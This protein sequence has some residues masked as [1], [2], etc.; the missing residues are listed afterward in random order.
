M[1]KRRLSTQILASQLTILV[2]TVLIGFGLFASAERD[3][4]DQE[5]KDRALAMADT[6][7]NIP[8]IREAME[9]GDPG[10]LVQSTVER[11]RVK[12]RAAYIVVIDLQGVRHSH[13]NP[14]LIGRRVEEPLIALDGRDH[15]GIDH[16]SLGLSA[17]GKAPIYG[18]SGNLV[19]EVSAGILESEVTSALHRELPVFA[20]YFG[21][22]LAVGVAASYLLARRLKRT[23]FGL[24][25]HDFATLLQEREAM[26]HGIREGVIGCDQAGRVTVVNDE[27]RRLLGIGTGG[28]GRPLTELVPPGRL[29]DLLDGQAPADSDETVVTDEHCL[30]INRMPVHL[31]GREL[32]SIATLR[33]RTELVGV[34]RE[35]DN[36]RGLTDALRA[37]QHEFAN[38][39]HTLAG[40]IE[41]DDRAEALAFIAE[42]QA[43]S[44]GRAEALRER[45]GAP[46]VAALILAKQ[47]VA[48]ERGI[49]LELSL[50]SW[51][52]EAPAHPQTLLTVLGNLLD[53]AIDAAA[54]GPQPARVQLHLT[55]GEAGTTVRVAD[56][57]AGVDP[58]VADQI[59]RDGYSTKPAR[60]T[61]RRGLGLALVHRVVARLD[62]TVTVST[63]PGAVFTVWLPPSAR[64]AVAAAVR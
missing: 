8:V 55:Q 60:G 16:G 31:R 35:L 39:M 50:D 3:H 47:T 41:L 40:L 49:D 57:G 19:G 30:A 58:A 59:F 12:S 64:P 25:L 24:E 43:G 46:L 13:P 52:A 42:V 33:D 37:Q 29:R 2:A 63:G 27:A 36:V 61:V 56:S 62:G 6:V 22:A 51:L 9:Y 1:A 15:T 26:L 21:V 11:I 20:L 23:T 4:L 10:G 32:G 28:L 5:Y 17:N 38:Q 14:A 44:A 48:A 53:N 45:I 18:P 54:A 7:A 34:L